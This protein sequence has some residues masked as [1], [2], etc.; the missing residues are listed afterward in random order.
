MSS[1]I[2]GLIDESENVSVIYI[3]GKPSSKYTNQAEAKKDADRLRV[4]FPNKKIEVKQEMREGTYKPKEV[5]MIYVDG[6]PKLFVKDM[7]TAKQHLAAL[8]TKFPNKEFE[9]KQEMHETEAIKGADGKRCWKGKR[10]A[11]TKNG[12]DICVPVKEGVIV[13]HDATD[14]E[15]AILGGAGTMSLSRLKKKAHGEATALANDISKGS[16]KA[17]AYNIKQLANTLNTIAAAEEEMKK[18]YFGEDTDMRFA[19]EKTAAVNPYGGLKD[20]SFRGD[21]SEEVDEAREMSPALRAAQKNLVDLSTGEVRRREDAKKAAARRERE[22]QKQAARD[23]RPKKPSLDQI[24]QEVEHAISN[25]FPDGDPSD[26]LNPYMERNN[27]TWDDI[28][29]AAKKNGYNDLWDYWN[30]LAQDIENDAYYDWMAAKRPEAPKNPLSKDAADIQHRN[31]VAKKK[32]DIRARG[33]FLEDPDTSGAVGTQPGGWRTVGMKPAGQLDEFDSFDNA[34]SYRVHPAGELD[35]EDEIDED[36]SYGGG[37][38]QGGYAGQSY[39]KFKPKMAGTNM[40]KS[41]ILKG[42]TGESE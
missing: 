33:F 6:E 21:I 32:P 20:R 24:W 34:T 22:Y 16:F 13:G 29:K 5:V 25:Y 38:G 3:D 2:K 4:K 39:R 35:N 26:Y 41:S 7:E 1:I 37:M 10:Y 11:G 42:I 27:L 36:T 15:V 23:A 9:I 17:A 8:K 28:T 18:L 12:K 31:W 19:A 14:P 40:K 30:A